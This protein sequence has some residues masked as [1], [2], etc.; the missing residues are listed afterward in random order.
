MSTK[1]ITTKQADAT[2][3]R[4][5]S[6]MARNTALATS[7][8]RP[9]AASGPVATYTPAPRK[10]VPTR[11]RANASGIRLLA[12]DQARIR[13]VLQA[14]LDLQVNLAMSEVIRLALRA[15]DPRR[16]TRQDIEQLRASDGRVSHLATVQP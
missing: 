7:T 15:Y 12:D 9:A 6:A 5:T 2:M 16:L 10:N 4:L 13:Q 1:T 11:S 14:G 8:P 3:A